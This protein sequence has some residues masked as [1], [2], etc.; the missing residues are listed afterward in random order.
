MA[1]NVTVP[2]T[3]SG[4]STAVIA[5]DDVG[6]Q[7]AQIVKLAVGVNGSAATEHT[8]VSST[9]YETNHVLKGSPGTLYGITG[10]SSRTS[11]QF[12]QLHNATSLPADSAVPVV[13]LIV[14]ATSNFSIDFGHFGR[15]FSTGIVICNSSTGPTKTIGSADCWFDAQLL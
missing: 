7:H 14:A 11:P 1:D 2:F 13:I 9:A 4:D 5:T 6:G 15:A 8:N 3:G 10:Y 12:I